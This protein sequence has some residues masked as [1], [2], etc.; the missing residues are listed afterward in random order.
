MVKG[1]DNIE[2]RIAQRRDDKEFRRR[3]RKKSTKELSQPMKDILSL[4]R[5][6]VITVLAIWIL[7]TFVFGVYIQNGASMYPKVLDGDVL[8]YYRLDYEYNV[9]ELVTFKYGETRYTARI[10]AVTGDI[11]DITE[12]GQLKVN[13][14]IQS[15][16][17]FYAT[18]K[19]ESELEYP[20][21][22]PEDSIFVLG[23]YRTIAVDS[24][25]FG[26]VATDDIDGE[27]MTI[28]RRR[29]F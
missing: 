1:E 22:V 4:L 18:F 13:G 12:E 28:L 16:E 26:A 10:V 29:G 5:N 20:Y 7:I 6:I 27:I 23:D 14:N 17:I 2:E 15:E 25:T 21:T 3:R 8:F 11:V 9:D 19:T 24:R